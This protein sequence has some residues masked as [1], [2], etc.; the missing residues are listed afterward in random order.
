MEVGGSRQGIGRA[1]LLCHTPPGSIAA[2]RRVVVNVDAEITSLPASDVE[3]LV[4]LVGRADLLGGRHVGGDARAVDGR[5]DTLQVWVNSPNRTVVLV[6]SQ[7]TS[8]TGGDEARTLLLQELSC[9]EERLRI[10]A[11]KAPSPRRSNCGTR[12]P[13]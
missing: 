7:N 5:F 1:R 12:G 4:D 8:F 9:L 10:Q 13:G 6:T 3:R 11:G 2:T